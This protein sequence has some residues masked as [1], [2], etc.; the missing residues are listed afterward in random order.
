M[1]FSLFPLYLD[2]STKY[3]KSINET[4]G[5]VLVI[6]HIKAPQI[7]TFKEVYQYD[8]MSFM[9]DAGG[10]IGLFLG[11]SILSIYEELMKPLLL[12]MEKSCQFDSSEKSPGK[13]LYRER[14]KS[15]RR[16]TPAAE[17]LI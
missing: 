10:I 11:F 1:Y 8:A 15:P 6:G 3:L 2:G 14:R 4:N 5:S 9:G 7:K 16:R 12:K 17:Q 13:I